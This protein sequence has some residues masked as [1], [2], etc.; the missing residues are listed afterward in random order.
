MLTTDWLNAYLCHLWAKP[1]K[2]TQFLA[3][4]YGT[5]K[6]FWVCT[7]FI[8]W[9]YFKIILPAGWYI[10]KRRQFNVLLFWMSQNE[11]DF[12]GKLQFRSQVVRLY[13]DPHIQQVALSHVPVEELK[14]KA[15][16]ACEKSKEGGQDGVDEKDCF[17]LEVLRWFGM[18]KQFVYFL[19]LLNRSLMVWTQE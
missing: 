18:H 2:K 7:K 6:L 14:K 10:W 9:D 5:L 8:I 12:F 17:L 1:H 13:E 16:E 15:K 19:F 11:R 4:S 3:V